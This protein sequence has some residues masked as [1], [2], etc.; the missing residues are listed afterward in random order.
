LLFLVLAGCGRLSF[1]PIIDDAGDQHEDGP[2]GPRWTLVQTGMS[3]ISTV[4]IAPSGSHNLIVVAAQIVNPG[5][6]RAPQRS[7]PLRSRW[8]A[9]T[10]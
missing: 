9:Y 6:A 7:G 3:T 4:T 8:R 2:S 5:T 10:E 1:A